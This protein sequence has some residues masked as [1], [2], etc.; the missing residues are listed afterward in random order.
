M[1]FKQ[2]DKVMFGDMP[3]MILTT[4]APKVDYPIQAVFAREKVVLGFRADGYFFQFGAGPK[5]VHVRKSLKQRIK[6]GVEY[7][8][9]ML[10][11][12]SSVD[13]HISED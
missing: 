5:L 10:R 9:T 4:S 8:S 6:E 13:D 1:D 11:K 7:V 12:R 3:G 2:G